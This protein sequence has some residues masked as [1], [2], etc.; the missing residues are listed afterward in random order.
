MLRTSSIRCASLRATPYTTAAKWPGFITHRLRHALVLPF[1][2]AAILGL[3]LPPGVPAQGAEV[4]AQAETLEELQKMSEQ[5]DQDLQDEIDAVEDIST[6][7]DSDLQTQ[8]NG[9]SRQLAEAL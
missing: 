9:L 1:G 3:M 5:G 2:V 4:S 8:I 7:T 6:Q